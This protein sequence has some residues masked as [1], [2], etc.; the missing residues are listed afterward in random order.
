MIE[1]GMEEAQ[2]SRNEQEFD[3]KVKKII[4]CSKKIAENQATLKEITYIRNNEKAEYERAKATAEEG[5]AGV[6]EALQLLQDFYGEN[7]P[8]LVQ[9][10]PPNAG[11]DG[12]NVGD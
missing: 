8:A 3:A 12:E 9:Y 11:R 7:A 1:I 2:K 6:E 4:D 10:V 5:K